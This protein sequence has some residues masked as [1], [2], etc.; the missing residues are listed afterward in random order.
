[1]QVDSSIINK[2]E[3]CVMCGLCL[4]HCPTYAVSQ[5]ESESPRGRISLVKAY[6]QGQLNS[7]D[8]LEKHLQSCTGCFSCQR[9][10]PANVEFDDI[11]DAGRAAYRKN[12]SFSSKFMQQL[13]NIALT[14]NRGQQL[15]RKSSKLA[16]RLPF[17]NKTRTG[18]LLKLVQ[19]KNKVSQ[20]ASTSKT[21]IFSGCTADV[22]DQTT[23][24]SLAFLMRKLGVEP[25]IPTASLCCGAL[26]QHSGLPQKALQHRSNIQAY[27]EKHQI[28]QYISI[29]SGCGRELIK[30]SPSQSAQHI[31]VH[32]WLL[33]QPEFTQ[34]QRKPLAKRVLVHTPCSMAA[35]ASKDMQTILSTIPELDLIEF[36]DDI[37][38]CGAGGM[39]L[40]SPNDS[41]TKLALKKVSRIKDLKPEI[42]VSANIGCAMQFR[43]TLA[44]ES[45]DIEVIH[46]ITLLARQI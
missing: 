3:Q 40:I 7:S 8:G 16:Q 18:R 26:A 39:Q 21:M 28:E 43:Q 32:K 14:T 12:L 13:V 33:S 23:L 19:Q 5:T 11:I 42:I 35:Q 6:L 15:V 24:R 30:F 9:V 37:N 36:D 25:H 10:C 34:I 20:I 41:N 1:M 45:L 2:T 31:D 27:C 17:I 44:D 22:F 38:C 4:P 29:A 46:P